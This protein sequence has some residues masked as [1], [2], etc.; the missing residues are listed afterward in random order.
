MMLDRAAP[1]KLFFSGFPDR[2][3]G[4]H[5]RLLPK[6]TVHAINNPWLEKSNPVPNVS[7]K[8]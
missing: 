4:L 7:K 6:E 3:K 1:V 8:G 5:P 2:P